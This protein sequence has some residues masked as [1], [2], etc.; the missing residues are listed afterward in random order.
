VSTKSCWKKCQNFES[1]KLKKE[2][3][4]R[5]DVSINVLKNEE[6]HMIDSL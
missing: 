2:K 5:P 6:I 3:G 1:K 4:K